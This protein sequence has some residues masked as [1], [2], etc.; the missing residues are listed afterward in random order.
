MCGFK[1]V[2]L[3]VVQNVRLL[4]DVMEYIVVNESRGCNKPLDINSVIIF[5]RAWH[6][7]CL[8]CAN[9]QKKLTE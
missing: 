6:K 8:V 4:L 1:E 9:C 7:R 2:R 3:K 5:D